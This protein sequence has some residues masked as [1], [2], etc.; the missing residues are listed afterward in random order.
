MNRKKLCRVGL[1]GGLALISGACGFSAWAAEKSLSLSQTIRLERGWNAFYL[2]VTPSASPNEVF[3][4]WPVV[5][6]SRFAQGEFEE[7]RTDTLKI[8]TGETTARPAYYV[9]SRNDTASTLRRVSTGVYFCFNT[10]AAPFETTLRGV[11]AAPVFQWH[12]TGPDAAGVLNAF[13]FSLQSD[14]SISPLAYVR[15][16]ETGNTAF[17]RLYGLDPAAPATVM[18]FDGATVRDGEALLATADCSTDWSGPIAISPADGLDFGADEKVKT[19]IFQNRSQEDTVFTFTPVSSESCAPATI[20]YRFRDGASNTAWKVLSSWSRPFAKGESWAVEFAADRTAASPDTRYGTVLRVDTDGSPYARVEVPLTYTMSAS[21]ADSWPAGLWACDLTLSKVSRVL[22]KDTLTHHLDTPAAVTVRLY[23]HVD[24]AGQ[25]RLL[26]RVIVAGM[27]DPEGGV[28]FHLFAADAEPPKNA[29]RVARLSSVVLPV[30]VPIVEG[31]GAFTG[32]MTFDFTVSKDSPSN[33]F[34][35]PFHPEHDN[36]DWNFKPLT[37]DG[38]NFEDYV[39]EIKPE[40][41]SLPQQVTIVCAGGSRDFDVEET[42][43][44]TGS[45]RFGHLRHEGEILAEGPC[46]LKR[47][48]RQAKLVRE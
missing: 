16:S 26:Q 7:T 5:S 14:K 44:G 23:L 43:T 8:S 41:F 29:T 22:A 12:P 36:L 25:A 38:D 3:G 15:G 10:N 18:L 6:V 21:S 9:W 17:Y 20:R 47:I 4:S 34:L 33:P 30:D 39:G 13:G 35:H 24:G 31:T 28:A 32:E 37:V 11:P 2:K 19:L 45:W 42:L 40:T 1:W 27:P 48:V 46:T